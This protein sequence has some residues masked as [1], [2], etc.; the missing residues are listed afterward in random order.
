MRFNRKSTLL[1]LTLCGLA[2]DTSSAQ[3]NI[4]KEKSSEASARVARGNAGRARNPV[5]SR[6]LGPDDGLSVIAAALESRVHLRFKPDC[7]HLVHAIYERAGF[8][9][10]YVSSSDLYNGIYE[11]QRV[12]RPQPG[13]LVV[14]PGHVGIV[15][16]PAQHFFFSA[17]RSG[18][19]IDSYNAPYWRERGRARFYRYIKLVVATDH[20]ATPQATHVT[21]TTLESAES[22]DTPEPGRS[23][24]DPGESTGSQ[25]ESYSASLEPS[26]G[27]I[28]I[29]V[30]QVLNSP[31]PKPEEIN[32]ALLRTFNDTAQALRGKEVFELSQ[33][34]IVFD[35]LEVKGAGLKGDQ[36]WAEVRISQQLS[37][38]KGRVNETKHKERYRWLLHRSEQGTWEVILPQEVIYVPREAAVSIFA[39]QLAV[40]TEGA[41]SAAR[42]VQDKALLAK[43]LGVLLER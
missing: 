3:Q 42:P 39:H 1:F 18:L 34:L 16:N 13:D 24:L 28:P 33:S 21:P 9:Y 5:A 30:V 11:F 22:N 14:W 27:N 43:L 12:I 38:T 15:I 10:S 23:G 2:L 4:Q 20:A 29:P 37:I 41:S 6:L 31:R 8:P 17:L 19:G 26:L 35:Q 40:L 25:P 7:S 36:G 32:K